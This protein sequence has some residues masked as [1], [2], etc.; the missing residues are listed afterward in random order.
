MALTPATA[1]R[2]GLSRTGLYRA[3]NSGSL[4]RIARGIYLPSDAPPADWDLIEAAARRTDATLCL[5]SALAH[6]DLTDEIPKAVDIAIRRGGR[7]PATDAAITWH[8]FARETFDLGREYITIPGTETSIGIYS[9]ERTIADAYRLRGQIGY[10]IA[11]DALKEWLRRGGR[12][13][14]LM[15]IATQLPRAK[16]PVLAALEMLA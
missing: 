1:D 7:I 6:Y 9:P 15:R 11:R 13:G 5:L 10:E 2:A 4:R 12:P 16:S 14:A 8:A 3:V